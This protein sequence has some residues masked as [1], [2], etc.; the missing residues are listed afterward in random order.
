[1]AE[2]V[3]LPEQLV[4]AQRA[5]DAAW[6]AVEQCRKSVTARRR[7]DGQP[8]PGRPWAGLAP[9]I[10]EETAEYDRLHASAI[11]AAEARRA[12]I[13]AAGLGH[14]YDV[15]QALHLAA[16]RAEATA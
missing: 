9:W 7:A 4:D 12:A 1:M 10:P 11:R 15:V 13:D 16:Q 14:G 2:V 6:A 5:V 8:E 3:D